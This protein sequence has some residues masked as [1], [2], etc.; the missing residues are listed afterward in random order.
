MELTPDAL[1]FIEQL[2]ATP[3]SPREQKV[4]VVVVR[5][6][7]IVHILPKIPDWYLQSGVSTFKAIV[8]LN[9]PTTTFTLSSPS[10]GF[11]MAVRDIPHVKLPAV[12]A[13]SLQVCLSEMMD[14]I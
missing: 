8:Q 14:V 3:P 10:A 12:C 13:L 9:T 4:A 2:F 11:L 5:A 6:L 7:V 1:Q